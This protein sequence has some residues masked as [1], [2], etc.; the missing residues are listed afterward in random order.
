M[1]KEPFPDEQAPE[2][3]QLRQ[4]KAFMKEL[5]AKYS[6]LNG[7]PQLILTDFVGISPF[8]SKRHDALLGMITAGEVA[9]HSVVRRKTMRRES[10]SPDPAKVRIM[11]MDSI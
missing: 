2:E 10:T 9:E 7:D 1:I 3:V 6:Y 5:F 8:S 4:L 11:I